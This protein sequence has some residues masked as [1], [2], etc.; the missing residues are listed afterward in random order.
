MCEADVVLLALGVATIGGFFLA[1]VIN[2]FWALSWL[3]RQNR[4]F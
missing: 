4:R 3:D 2:S 1:I